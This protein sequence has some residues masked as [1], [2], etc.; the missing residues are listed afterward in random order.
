MTSRL[1]SSGGRRCCQRPSH[2]LYACGTVLAVEDWQGDAEEDLT[3]ETF[4]KGKGFGICVKF[5]NKCFAQGASQRHAI[6]L[7][8]STLPF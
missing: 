7:C 8:F 4:M 6:N 2:R 5:L 3:T 1:K